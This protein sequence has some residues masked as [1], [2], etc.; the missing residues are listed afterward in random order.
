MGLSLNEIARLVDLSVP[1][2]IAILKEL[3]MIKPTSYE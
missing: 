2:V 3:G 1:S